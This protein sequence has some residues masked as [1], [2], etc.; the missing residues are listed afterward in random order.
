MKVSIFW[1]RRDLRLEDNN[2]LYETITQKKN[3]LPIFIFDDNILNELPI[4][5]PRVNFIYKTLFDIN[6]RLQNEN[7]SLLVLKGNIEEVW[8]DLIQK[9]TIDSVFINKDYEP[10]ANTRDLKVAQLLLSNGIE[11][12]SFKDQVIFEES[13]VVKANGEPYTVFTPYKRKWLELYTPQTPKPP[14]SFENFHKKNHPFPTMEELGFTTSNI[15]VRNFDLKGVSRIIEL[16]KKYS[17]VPMDLADASLVVIA[18]ELNIKEIITIDSDYYIYRT[19][20][21]EMITNVF[22]YQ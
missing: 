9:Y 14:L 13:E 21:K 6:H 20:D 17:D 4:D 18:E 12:H 8:K 15:Q 16:S 2:A 3:V 1:F 10:Y 11:F 7:T 22:A 5:D 19:V